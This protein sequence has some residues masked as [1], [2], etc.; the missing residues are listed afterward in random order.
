MLSV[1]PLLLLRWGYTALRSATRS[2][3]TTAALPS[4]PDIHLQWLP[5]WTCCLPPPHRRTS[6]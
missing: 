4:P 6:V 2:K 1:T 5:H 3:H